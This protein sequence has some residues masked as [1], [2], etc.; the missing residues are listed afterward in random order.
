MIA[1]LFVFLFNAIEANDIGKEQGER[2]I[3]D[4]VAVNQMI[5]AWADLHL[6]LTPEQRRLVAEKLGDDSGK[7]AKKRGQPESMGLIHVQDNKSVNVVARS[8]GGDVSGTTKMLQ[9]VDKVGNMELS[10][11]QKQ[12]L[13]DLNAEL[14]WAK[15]KIGWKGK[16]NFDDAKAF[17]KKIRD[18]KRK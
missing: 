14:G 16:K 6:D 5:V 11:G 15:K 9:C 7:S 2:A 4:A 8:L 13:N 18:K 3:R 10:P 17:Q 12:K 1:A